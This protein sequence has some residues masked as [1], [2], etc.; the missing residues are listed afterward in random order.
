M[1]RLFILSAF[2][3]FVLTSCGVPSTITNLPTKTPTE[4]PSPTVSP[5]PKPLLTVKV[6]SYNILWGA[7]VD[8]EFDENL[9][10]KGQDSQYG[11]DR[12]PELLSVIKELDPDILGIQEGA[13]WDRG[14]PSV[15]QK[16]AEEL[17]M[18]YFLAKG[19]A[20]ELNVMILSKFKIIETENLSP[21]VGNVGALRVK[22]TTPDG[23]P[24]NVFVVHLDPFSANIRLCEINTLIQ[25]MQPYFQQRTIV[26]G[27]FNTTPNLWDHKNLKETGMT[28]VAIEQS[29]QI[30][31]IWA[32][33]SMN[34]SKTDW[35]KSFL[36]PKN[37]SDHHPIGA[38]I[39]IF[40]NP[41]SLPTVTPI[42]PTP[43]IKPIPLIYDFITDPQVLRFDNIEDACTKPKWNS[44]WTTEKFSDGVIAIVGEDYWKAGVSRNKDF[45]EGQ[46]VVL[47]F[48]FEK[49]TEA[50][51]FFDSGDWSTNPYR[52][53]GMNIRQDSV[54]TDLWQGKTGM[55]GKNLNGNFKPKPET[56][57][58]L[59]I[60]IS[61]N[62]EFLEAV[63]EPNDPSQ[64]VTYHEQL[65]EKWTGLTWRFSVGANTGNVL[66]DDFSEI[67]FDKI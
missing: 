66:I 64:V 55:G 38:E 63:W 11:R 29:W 51:I 40:S 46:G 2:F 12:L 48:K 56:W 30:D 32:S 25:Y 7:G 16:V 57:Y 28:L 1:R 65:G 33:P 47:R 62:G 20:S 18:N 39:A 42:P 49:G 36:P 53:F 31:Q 59:M 3:L 10:A 54:Q 19:A 14:T 26:M 43:V 27:D 61:K 13:G 52:R 44:D 45:S 5:T 50:N 34:W 8:R 22:L 37:I 67:I 24:L 15:I 58:N 35:F 4:L 6:M 60:V 17:N 41:I 9:K 23:Q 21:E